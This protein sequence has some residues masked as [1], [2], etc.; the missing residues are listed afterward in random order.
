[1]SRSEGRRTAK[2][3]PEATV[4]PDIDINQ[5]LA[6]D[7]DEQLA[8]TVGAAIQDFI[9]GLA[10][11]FTTAKALEQTAANWLHKAQTL[12]L[13]TSPEAD[14]ALQRFCKEVTLERKQ[15]EEH[16]RITSLV[17]QFHRRMTARRSKATDALEEAAR[18][19][20]HWHNTYVAAERRRAA[21]E[22]ER[23]R[24]AAEEQARR[25]REAE[26]RRMEE[27]ALKREAASPELSGRETLFV[28]AI[29]AGY[30][31]VQAAQRAGYKDPAAVAPR[32]LAPGSK[33]QAA[34]QSRLEAVQ[35]RK[36]AEARKA[37]PVQVA[38]VPTV[39]ANVTRAGNAYDRT[40]LSAELLDAR[41]LLTAFLGCAPE[42]F[43][44]RYGIPADLFEVN[45]A[46]LNQYARSLGERL[47]EW[48]GVRLKKDTRVV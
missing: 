16:W 40:T 36:Q 5:A 35:I 23:L 48:P 46:R 12:T 29:V 3:T 45:P 19:A 25:D 2:R 27:E 7:E 38:D 30:G 8:V 13:P 17:S 32:L 33:V 42:D 31:P 34:I 14:E 47:N 26:L 20:N 22:Q 44:N 24:R 43:K 10:G 28:H 11:F 39:K 4:L 9:R 6:V 18:L 41:A 21:E 37:A 1:M 15:V